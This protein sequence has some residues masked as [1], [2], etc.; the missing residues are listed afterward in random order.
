M[1]YKDA[2]LEL[3]DLVSRFEFGLTTLSM[4]HTSIRECTVSRENSCNA[5]YCVYD[6]LYDIREKMRKI[7]DDACDQSR[8]EK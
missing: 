6:Y 8:K 2:I 3:D 1:S 7:I 4:V 5:V